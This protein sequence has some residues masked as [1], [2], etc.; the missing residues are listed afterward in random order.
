MRRL[1]WV[2]FSQKTRRQVLSR[3][4]PYIVEQTY[5]YHTLYIYI[6]ITDRISKLHIFIRGFPFCSVPAVPGL[7]C[8][9]K[10]RE[11][12]NTLLVKTN[13]VLTSVFVFLKNLKIFWGFLQALWTYKSSMDVSMKSVCRQWHLIPPSMRLYFNVNRPK[14]R[15]CSHCCR[16]PHTKH[17][18]MP[19]GDHWD[20]FRQMMDSNSQI[21][22]FWISIS[23]HCKN[24]YIYIG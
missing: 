5:I 1:A 20:W 19:N 12:R 16:I 4:D 11:S 6:Y 21:S 2:S 10:I 13:F 24:N 17:V 23:V 14:G 7:Q 9:S 15:I 8:I 18:L 3:R 22:R